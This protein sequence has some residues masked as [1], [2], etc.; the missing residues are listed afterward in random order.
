MQNDSRPLH[1][2]FNTFAHSIWNLRHWNAQGCP[3]LHASTRQDLC[4]PHP[5]MPPPTKETPSAEATLPEQ[6]IG[7]KKNPIPSSSP[8]YSKLANI[9]YQEEKKPTITFETALWTPH[10]TVLKL[11]SPNSEGDK[12]QTALRSGMPQAPTPCYSKPLH[13]TP[14]PGNTA[15][16]P[17]FQPNT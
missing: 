16:E 4:P 9:S 1:H 13:A 11:R 8:E 15:P 5:T 6:T 3:S 12:A 7:K 2:Y 14:D 17:P 10:L